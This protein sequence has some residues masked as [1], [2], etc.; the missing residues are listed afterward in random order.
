MLLINLMSTYVEEQK[1]KVV[2]LCG[3]CKSCPRVEVGEDEVKIGEEGN[4]CV[5]KKSEWKTLLEKIRSG[6][7]D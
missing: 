4:F 1:M 7:L 5:L 3:S 6:E 2:S